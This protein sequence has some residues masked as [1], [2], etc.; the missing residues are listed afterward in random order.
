MA[1]DLKNKN[2]KDL[3]KLL[4]DKREE[5]RAF[6]FGIAGSKVRNIKEGRNVRREIA[7]ILTELNARRTN[8]EES[9]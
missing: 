7:Q 9:K 6:R 3:M 2:D 4:V 8:K 5:W 1:T